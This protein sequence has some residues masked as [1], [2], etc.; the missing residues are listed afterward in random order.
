MRQFKAILRKDIVMELRTKEMLTSMGLY[1][2]LT[3]VVYYVALSQSGT[4]FEPHRRGQSP[5]SR[6]HRSTYR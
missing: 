6:V 3:L 2:L 4:G 5:R 1:T